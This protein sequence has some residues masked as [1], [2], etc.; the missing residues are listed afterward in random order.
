MSMNEREWIEVHGDAALQRAQ[1]EGYQTKRGIAERLFE[2]LVTATGMEAVDH[3][4]WADCGERTSPRAEAFASRDEV[5]DA[6]RE[7]PRPDKWV[8]EVSRIVRVT[9]SGPLGLQHFTGVVVEVRGPDRA[10][11]SRKALNFE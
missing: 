5:L 1:A 10:M 4:L 3:A 9:V 8:L 11:I 7:L 2:M 6:V